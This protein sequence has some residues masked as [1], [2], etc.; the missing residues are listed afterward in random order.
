[1]TQSL[2]LLLYWNASPD[3][4]HSPNEHDTKRSRLTYLSKIYKVDI[5]FVAKIHLQTIQN[6]LYG[7]ESEKF[8]EA[9][10]PQGV[11]HNFT[12][13]CCKTVSKMSPLLGFDS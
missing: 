8:Y 13:A 6:A 2:L 7:H 12:I 11:G 1:M 5:S 10:C 9:L 3:G 4:Y